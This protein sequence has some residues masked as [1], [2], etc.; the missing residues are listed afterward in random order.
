MAATYRSSSKLSFSKSTG[1]SGETY[2]SSK[3]VSTAPDS[4]NDEP[5]TAVST[6]GDAIALGDNTAT[7]ASVQASVSSGSSNAHAVFTAAA[8]GGTAYTSTYADVLPSSGGDRGLVVSGTS[9]STSW[10]DKYQASTSSSFIDYQ[11]L[12]FDALRNGSARSEPAPAPSGGKFAWG[13]SGGGSQTGWGSWK[14]DGNT[15]SFDINAAAYGDNSY[16]DVQVTAFTLEDMLSS[17]SAIVLT[18]IG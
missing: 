8:Q 18:G 2:T 10:N 3:R 4:T 12:D 9:T 5:G 17:V 11:M 16:V 7:T 14:L 6:V 15:S 1:S 13:D